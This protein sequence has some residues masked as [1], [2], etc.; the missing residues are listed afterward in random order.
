MEIFFNNKVKIIN[1]DEKIMY[2]LADVYPYLPYSYIRGTL[3][4]EEMRK[5]FINEA[6]KDIN[7]NSVKA[8]VIIEDGDIVGHSRI[9]R[10]DWD[11]KFFGV[12]IYKL[13]VFWTAYDSHQLYS[14]LLSEI[15]RFCNN[16]KA[17]LI[18]ANLYLDD[19]SKI[20]FLENEGFYL[21]D[22]HCTYICDFSKHKIPKISYEPHILREYKESDSKI[23]IEIAEKSFLIDRYHSDLKLSNHKCN[24]FYSSW[25]INSCKGEIADHVVVVE[26]EGEPVGYMTYVYYGNFNRT[27]NT[28]LGGFILSAVT[29]KAR[30]EGIYSKMIHYGMKWL[31]EKG[32]NYATLGTQINNISVQRSWLKFG[33]K[34][35]ISGIWMNKWL[36]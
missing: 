8:I 16:K 7:N 13:S 20:Q 30:K 31:G 15:Y 2:Q 34:I 28:N 26:K 12:E 9:S 11:S 21:V 17:D 3:T 19:I 33:F 18:Q 6:M 4:R 14:I 22:A 25:T 32:T 35:A 5:L 23:L 27:I 1:I 36:K 29:P 24:A 10:V